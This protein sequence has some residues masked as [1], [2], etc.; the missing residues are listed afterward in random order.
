[1]LGD[2]IMRIQCFFT[3]AFLWTFLSNSVSFAAKDYYT[4]VSRAFSDAGSAELA[5]IPEKGAL[6]DG[7]CVLDQSPTQIVPAK[8]ELKKKND[9]VLE[10]I[11]SLRVDPIEDTFPSSWEH[12][13]QLGLEKGEWQ[14]ELGDKF[15]V[16]TLLRQLNKNNSSVW[17][18][19]FN[20]WIFA[21]RPE[22]NLTLICTF[23][24]TKGNF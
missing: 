17:I 2:K 21:T 8:I 6:F 20:R 9:P 5:A 12:R 14:E 10:D 11:I 7:Y 13:A 15:P 4:L 1:M 19:K 24:A 3:F 22:T 18:V 16:V 23:V